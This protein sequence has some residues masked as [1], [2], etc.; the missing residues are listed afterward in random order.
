MLIYYWKIT[1][2]TVENEVEEEETSQEAA[3]MWWEMLL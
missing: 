1:Q 2:C 3:E